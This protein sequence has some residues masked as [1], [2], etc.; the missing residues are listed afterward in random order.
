VNKKESDIRFR[1]AERPAIKRITVAGYKSI[2]RELSIEIRPLTILAG[3]NSSGK[4]SIMQPLL[5]LKQTLEAPYNPGALLLD[6][7]NIK[8]SSAEQLFSRSAKGKHGNTLS[9]GIENDIGR[10]ITTYFS[11]P[12]KGSLAVARMDYSGEGEDGS[13]RADMEP[14]QVGKIVADYASADDSLFQEIKSAFVIQPNRC[15]LEVA[16]LAS[17]SEGGDE[18]FS[19]VAQVVWDSLPTHWEFRLSPLFPGRYFARYITQL[20]HL[21]GLRGN[22][23]RSY[24]VTGVGSSFP[25]TF[26]SYTASVIA[27]WQAQSDSEKLKMIGRDLGDLGLTWKVAANRVSDTRVELQVGRLPKQS[28]SE[29]NDLIN[30][31]DVGFGVSQCLPVLV[32]LH[33]AGRGQLV[34][35][36]QPEIHLHPRAQSAMAKVL[37]NAAK[38]GVRVVAETHS[39]LLL[40]GIQT[41]VAEGELAPDLVKL[42]WFRRRD[43]G[44]TMIQ[45][46]DL[47]ETGAFGDWPEDF[48]EVELAAESRYLDAAESRQQIH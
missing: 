17:L 3:A 14:S 6:G 34:Y 45:S 24:P 18:F 25:G 19:S 1:K 15:F 11:K 28:A 43:D 36:E 13:L 35:L 21:P 26:E 41:L 40:L 30:I 23:E 12:T 16:P 4:S 48:A 38:R 39:S 9:V 22:P 5:L 27:H 29:A 46:A 37:A 47:D 32:A 8:F 7:P 44:S 2:S 33:E 31:A 42:H 20:I 10:S